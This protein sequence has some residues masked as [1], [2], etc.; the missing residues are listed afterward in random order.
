MF[1]NN[2][3]FLAE[4]D[5]LNKND[6]SDEILSSFKPIVDAIDDQMVRLHDDFDHGLEKDFVKQ[7]LLLQARITD[8]IQLL[9]YMLSENN[10]AVLDINGTN[11][12]NTKDIKVLIE[13]LL[14]KYNAKD[15]AD[16]LYSKFKLQNVSS[17]TAKEIDELFGSSDD[18]D[19]ISDDTLNDIFKEE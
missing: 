18:D 13:K 3:Y 7:L 17:E 11:N 15:L 6:K 16:Q 2:D 8:A 1:D 14:Y 4:L 12:I 10:A 9:Q 19:E 5:E